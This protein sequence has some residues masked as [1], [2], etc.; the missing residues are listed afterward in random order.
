[1]ADEV[2]KKNG[3]LHQIPLT[4]VDMR[5]GAA[6]ELTKQAVEALKDKTGEEQFLALAH[7]FEKALLMGEKKGV[8]GACEYLMVHIHGLR[9][10]YAS[11]VANHIQSA[12]T[13]LIKWKDASPNFITL[14]DQQELREMQKEQST[15]IIP[16]EGT[17]A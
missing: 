6:I 12:L 2:E 4:H 5:Y 3:E 16:P 8:Y 13:A 10:R 14:K 7:L 15:L 17:K 11:G 1:M 9:A